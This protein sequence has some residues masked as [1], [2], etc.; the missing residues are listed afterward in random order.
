[1]GIN[2]WV[3]LSFSSFSLLCFF[4]LCMPGYQ[5]M[6]FNRVLFFYSF[7]LFF[8]FSPRFYSQ[9]PDTPI[10]VTMSPMETI[11]L[12][13]PSPLFVSLGPKIKFQAR[14]SGSEQIPYFWL[15]CLLKRLT[16]V[17]AAWVVEC[18]LDT[19][20]YFFLNRFIS[21]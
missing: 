8:F 3:R 16:T 7:I 19:F 21:L 20:F 4:S 13:V 12:L 5:C 9:M 11:F 6:V 18:Y 17:A 1:M 2:V 14:S 15:G 10:L